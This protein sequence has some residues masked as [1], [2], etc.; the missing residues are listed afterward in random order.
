MGADG[1]ACILWSLCVENCSPR[2][3]SVHTIYHNRVERLYTVLE[4]SLL[5][6]LSTVIYREMSSINCLFMQP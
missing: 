5:M 3:N 6:G 4:Q 1:L 2:Y